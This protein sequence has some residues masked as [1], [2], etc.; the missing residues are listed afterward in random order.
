MDNN[1]IEKLKSYGFSLCSKNGYLF[2]KNT[3]ILKPNILVEGAHSTDIATIH[4]ADEE[5]LKGLCYYSTLLEELPMMFP[6]HHNVEAIIKKINKFADADIELKFHNGFAF[7]VI[8][9]DE[10]DINDNHIFDYLLSAMIKAIGQLDYFLQQ[11][12]RYLQKK[13][14]NA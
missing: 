4:Y 14:W 1:T 5:G 12:V 2:N 8:E 13:Y 10:N 11:R 9:C 7:L 6:D 3:F